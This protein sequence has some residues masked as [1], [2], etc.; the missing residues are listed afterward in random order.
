MK[1]RTAEILAEETLGAAGTKTI[2]LNVAEPISRIDIRYKVTKSK[3]GMDAHPAADITKIELV[4]GSDV[5]HSLSGYENQALCIYDRKVPTMCHG[6]HTDA[7]DEESEYGLDFGR[8]L[9]DPV[10]AFL[11]GKFRNPQLK[12]TYNSIVSD[13]GATSPKLEVIGHLFDEKAISPVGFLMSKEHHDAA[14]PANDSYKYVELPTDHPIRQMLIR[15]Y[16]AAYTPWAC[17]EGVRIDED[18]MK[19]IPLDWLIEEYYRVMKGVWQAVEE[20]F[21]GVGDV[22]GT[23]TFYVTPTDY[24]ASLL[25]APLSTAY[26]GP[27]GNMQGGKVTLEHSATSW[28]Q[29]T[30][31]GYLP[32][33]CIQ[34]PFGLQNE[35]DDWYDVTKKG[36][37]RLRIRGGSVGTSAEFQVVLQQLRKY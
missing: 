29:G 18:N 2:D 37:I 35:L 27:S 19:R 4:D 9:W 34:F 25:G 3:H 10:L 30:A 15:G 21:Y 33:H 28:F 1:Y 32:N 26:G 22:A 31:R 20:L 12:V 14:A 7:S 24:F 11:P 5:L 8:F 13:T 16:E 17:V 23:Y 36:S 6:Q